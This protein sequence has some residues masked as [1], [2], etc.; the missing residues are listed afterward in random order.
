M[1]KRTPKEMICSAKSAASE[2]LT[3]ASRRLQ[4]LLDDLVRG[5]ETGPF[6]IARYVLTETFWV[7]PTINIY[8]RVKHGIRAKAK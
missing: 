5:G 2:D 1:S 3:I 6:K 8:S 4:P 7:E